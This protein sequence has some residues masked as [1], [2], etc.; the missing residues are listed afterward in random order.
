LLTNNPES[1]SYEIVI[2][3]CFVGRLHQRTPSC[4]SPGKQGLN[5]VGKISSVLI[6]LPC[7][8]WTVVW[9]TRGLY[10]VVVI[11]LASAFMGIESSARQI[12]KIVW[13]R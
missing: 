2:Q 9:I 8:V 5:G 7:A 12:L 4:S 10:W 6:I 11:L 13:G 1:Q 3:S